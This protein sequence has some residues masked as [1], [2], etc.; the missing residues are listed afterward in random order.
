MWQ[1]KTLAENFTSVFSETE[2]RN[3]CPRLSFTGKE[4]ELQQSCL[5]KG[6]DVG[7]LYF[8]VGMND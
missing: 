2:L 1:G 3:C 4:A 7:E 5:L 6:V 8:I